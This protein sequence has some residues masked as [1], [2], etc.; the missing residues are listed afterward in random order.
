MESRGLVYMY[1]HGE[2]EV[3]DKWKGEGGVYL[4]PFFRATNNS[5]S[6]ATLVSHQLHLDFDETFDVSR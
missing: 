2:E 4:R 3:F 1:I 5:E 6:E